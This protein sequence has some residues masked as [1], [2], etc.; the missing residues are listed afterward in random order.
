MPCPMGVD[1]APL[2]PC[3]VVGR[4][5][6][7]P[8]PLPK[9][10]GASD[11][12]K[13]TPTTKSSA[14]SR[15][16]RPRTCRTV[17]DYG[18]ELPLLDTEK[19]LNS[20]I[21]GTL[22]ATMISDSRVVR[23]NVEKLP[24]GWLSEAFWLEKD[25]CDS[26]GAA[27]ENLAISALLSPEASQGDGAGGGGR[28]NGWQTLSGIV[29]AGNRF[30]TSK[31]D[32]CRTSTASSR[33]A[34]YG[35]YDCRP[36]SGKRL[37]SRQRP[38]TGRSRPAFGTKR[39]GIQNVKSVFENN[40]DVAL[41][42]AEYSGEELE[43]V[44]LDV[45]ITRSGV[46]G[47][48]TDASL[49]SALS[50]RRQADLSVPSCRGGTAP[51]LDLPSI[52]PPSM[53]PATDA[54]R[55]CQRRGVGAAA[56][57]LTS[58]GVGTVSAPL[59]KRTHEQF[60]SQ[61]SRTVVIGK[62]PLKLTATKSKLSFVASLMPRI[63]GKTTPEKSVLPISPS[64][65]VPPELSDS[66]DAGGLL[67]TGDVVDGRDSDS[68]WRRTNPSGRLM[69]S[70]GSGHQ[71]TTAVESVDEEPQ[72]H[73]T[74]DG[75]E[76]LVT[77]SADKESSVSLRGEGGFR[78][79]DAGAGGTNCAA[80][81]VPEEMSPSMHQ[82]SVQLWASVFAKLQSEGQIHRDDLPRVLELIGVAAPNKAWINKIFDGISK[83]STLQGDEYR[84]FLE[85]YFIEQRQAYEQAFR[86][87]DT[88]GSG[89][90]DVTELR[91]LLTS[92]GVEP[93]AHVLCQV[94]EEVDKDGG[95]IL[96]M[97]EF[98]EVMH[99]IH[100]RECF[101]RD[102]YL[103]LKDLHRRFDRDKSGEIDTKE[104]MHIL[105]WLGYNVKPDVAHRIAK[106]VDCDGSGSL[107]LR[108]Y[109]I[110]MRKIRDQEVA[111]VKKALFENDTDHSGTVGVQELNT[112]LGV[113]G[114]VCDPVAVRDAAV[115]AGLDPDDDELDLGELW[116]LLTLYRAREGLNS[117]DVAEVKSAFARY[118]RD[119]SGEL[120]V[121]DVGKALRWLGYAPS[122]EL[123]QQHIH[124]VDVDGSGT[125]TEFELRK[126]VRMQR[127]RSLTAATKAFEAAEMSCKVESATKGTISKAAAN[128]AVRSLCF[129]GGIPVDFEPRD[130]ECIHIVVGPRT[131]LELIDLHGF[132]R[133]AARCE[134]VACQR[135]RES[136]G[137]TEKEVEEL[138]GQFQ[139]FDTDG[140]GDISNREII[141]VVECLFP[142]F[143]HDVSMRSK[144]KQMLNEVDHDGNGSLNFHDFLRLVRQFRDLEDQERAAKEQ[145]A[146]E[147]TSFEAHEVNDF[148]ELFLIPHATHDGYLT[149]DEFKDMIA[150]VCPLGDKNATDLTA[151]FY[152]KASGGLKTR[153]SKRV[154]VTEQEPRDMIDFPEFLLLM[155]KL[156]DS[157]FAQI[158]ERT[159]APLAA[160][161]TSAT[162]RG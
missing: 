33:P 128:V 64:D 41:K 91:D 66:L 125:L 100:T 46:L 25:I 148:R 7:P 13:A 131:F 49:L 39:S 77:S 45:E 30:R 80:V 154:F 137:F 162:N 56:R 86:D 19:A 153:S 20:S 110:L 126:L 81:S 149:L 122:F 118:E 103:C 117:Q 65:T 130:D 9:L 38:T 84:Y 1:L 43:H 27:S 6:V 136:G 145:H 120:S 115:E 144:L 31:S 152:T 98:R 8:I 95:G 16:S 135:F 143:A 29:S 18:D 119:G 90:V 10:H 40:A 32:G 101:T 68:D 142:R 83:Y 12:Q 155:K 87:C 63:A 108:E 92:L 104:L 111:S 121:H 159:Q 124:H 24:G 150:T 47:S 37:F 5:K 44:D 156:L 22:P 94:I 21:S 109:L 52:V 107:N 151:M 58:S 113:L 74:R 147:E 28:R 138:R 72:H 50:P 76:D 112:V 48:G 129:P 106:D 79:T 123:Q 141:A 93:M 146:I 23:S 55:L 53:P 2:H 36:T 158:K 132:L 54:E 133:F 67:P 134:K 157:N 97:E 3:G 61:K 60:A 88:D 4:R 69:G 34:P 14:L 42:T 15:L 114:C 89:S 160:A 161:S 26:P 59:S 73:L 70:F 51:S 105:G 11:E 99:I 78:A 57:P 85:L 140:S 35:P 127:E 75:S 139:R 71:M 116:R 102:E 62:V 82:Q 17:S 96:D